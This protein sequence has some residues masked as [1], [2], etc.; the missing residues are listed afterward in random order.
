MGLRSFIESSA[1]LIKLIGRP[2]RKDLWASMKISLLGLGVLG[3]LGFIIK[4]IA[5]MLVP[6][7]AATSTT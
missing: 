1:R 2:E 4:F 3:V 7:T 6:S 5:S